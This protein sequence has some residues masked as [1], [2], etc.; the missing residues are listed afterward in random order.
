MAA[1]NE[2]TSPA[3]DATTQISSH[4]VA[5]HSVHDSNQESATEIRTHDD[6]Y[7]SRV[8][9]YTAEKAGMQ[10]IDRQQIQKTVYEMSKDSKYFENSMKLNERVDKKIEKM[11]LQIAQLTSGKLKALQTRIDEKIIP[12]LEKQ[13][14][15]L[16][17]IAVIDMDMFYAAVEM[18][19]N[20]ALKDVPLAVGSL[21]MI[22]TSNYIARKYGVRSAMPGFIGKKL[23][24]ELVFVPT[25]YSKYTA[26]A[27]DIREIF[28]FYDPEFVAFSLDEASLDL[29]AFIDAHWNDYAMNLSQR[30][31]SASQ[32][33]SHDACGHASLH[34]KHG[35]MDIAAAV[36]EDIRQKIFDKTGLTASAGIAVN[37][38]LAKVWLDIKVG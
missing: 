10:D 33:T 12:N 23:C 34:L 27:Q 14:D 37:T 5:L 28:A 3:S 8:F 9:V 17:V 20:P 31:D 36:V 18:R 32:S 21:S 26:V 35:R 29:S 19:D 6:D 13:R 38:M 15:T 25:N 7:N 16:K 22:S 30:C 11:Q 1:D 2:N 24:P 4:F